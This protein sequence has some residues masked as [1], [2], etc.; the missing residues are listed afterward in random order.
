MTDEL[1]GAKHYLEQAD[2]IAVANNMCTS[3]EAAQMAQAAA[4]IALAEQVKRIADALNSIDTVLVNA[5]GPMGAINV[6]NTSA[7]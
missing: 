7:Y 1:T 4:L 3:G 5:S 6:N 2:A